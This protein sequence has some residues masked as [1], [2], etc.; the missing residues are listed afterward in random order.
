MGNIVLFTTSSSIEKYWQNALLDSYQTI[1]IDNLQK[2]NEYLNIN[3]IP[4][5]IMLDELSISN[6]RTTLKNLD[7]FPHL[8]ILLFSSAP[9]IHHASTLIGG[10]VKGYENSYLNKVNLLKMIDSI[11]NGKS[12]LYADLANHIINKHLHKNL[13]IEASFMKMLTPKEKVI[14]QMV[15]DGLSNKEIV[16]AE[17]ITLSTVK[18]HIQKIFEKTGVSDRVS[19]A[20]MFK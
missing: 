4:M 10:N 19:L 8:N 11:K 3:T 17:K 6:I 20:L 15:A 9:D 16:Q 14:A 2:L 5:T 18:G 13:Y 7:L 12:W 1:H